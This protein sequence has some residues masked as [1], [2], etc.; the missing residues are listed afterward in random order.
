MADKQLVLVGV[1]I[2]YMPRIVISPMYI[3]SDA[4]DIGKENTHDERSSVDQ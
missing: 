1:E 2:G 4:E 3:L